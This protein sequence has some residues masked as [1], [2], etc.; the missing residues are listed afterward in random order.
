MRL[1]GGRAICAILAL[2]CYRAPTLDVGPVPVGVIVDARL[3]YY[4]ISA[5]SV[6]EINRAIGR[7][8]PRDEG[9]AWGATTRN[10]YHSA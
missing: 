7:L 9:R 5:A 2:A 4:D 10:S 3:R 1:C 8:G 6:A